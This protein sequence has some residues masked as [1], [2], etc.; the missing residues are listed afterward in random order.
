MPIKVNIISINEYYNWINEVDSIN[1]DE[2]Y[3]LLESKEI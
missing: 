1:F 3:D 2:Y